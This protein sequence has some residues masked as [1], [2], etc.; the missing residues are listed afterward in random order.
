VTGGG[1]T[2]TFRIRPGYRFSPPSGRPVTAA[3]FRYSIER[4]LSP[5]L[6]PGAPAF[7]YLSD[8]VGAGAF[9][10]GKAQHVSG[11][12]V[13]GNRL[14]IRLVAPAGDFLGRLSMPFFAAVPIGTPIV[15]GG[16]QTPIPS[17][18]PYYLAVSFQD[19]L[20]VLERNPNY[21]GPRPARLERIVYSLNNLAAHEV[22]QIE[23]GT[24]D[25][26]ADVMGDSQFKRAGPLDVRYGGARRSAG[27][28][29]MRYAP[30]VGNGFIQFNTRSGPF[31]NVRLRRAVDLALDRTALAGVNGQIPSSQYLPPAFGVGGGAPVEHDLARARALVAGFRGPVTL[32][33]GTDS[34][35]QAI[36][37]VVKAS[38]A[39]IGLGVRVDRRSVPYQVLSGT[40]WQML[41]G[42]WYYDWPDPAAFFNVFFDPKAYR[43][44]DS[45]PAYSVPPAYRRMLEAAN[46]LRGA[47]RAVAY[48]SLAA[49]LERDVAPIAVYGAPVTPE[50]FSARLGCQVEQP[51]I[52]GVDIGALCVRG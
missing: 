43:P 11:I 21:H 16:V 1:R 19:D 31:A 14:R 48:R 38:L 22:Q 13:S 52:G 49:R 40:H 8:V 10:A 7:G 23:A 51:V 41:D 18:G 15:D 27:T 30:V 29:A 34:N 50:F 6:G 2:Y 46:R 33:T 37:S 47:A 39:R 25:Y 36:A 28:P 4:A 12:T 20:R 17:A 45:P 44:P 32:T 3:T 9:H 26:T 42:G 5:G 24:A 35:S